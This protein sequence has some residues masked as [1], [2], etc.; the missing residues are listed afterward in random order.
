MSVRWL[1]FV[2]AACGSGRPPKAG[3]T[4]PAARGPSTLVAHADLVQRLTTAGYQLTPLDGGETLACNQ[5]TGA[6]I[7]L[8]E[9]RC[10]GDCIT[11]ENNLEVFRQALARG[12][13]DRMVTCEL[14]DTGKQCD[15]SYF[16]FEGDIYRLEYRYFDSTGRLVG[17]RNATDYPEYCNGRAI[18]EFA[19]AIPD[20]REPARDVKTICSD[21]SHEHAMGNPMDDL[22]RF[23]R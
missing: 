9:L 17:Q 15:T 20:C 7:C 4:A 21:H 16:R 19:G 23:L 5:K 12:P 1:V 6:C 14:A 10:E 8:T 18:A 3:I 11:L 22:L 13:D 2:V